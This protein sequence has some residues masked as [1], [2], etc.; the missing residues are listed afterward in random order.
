MLRTTAAVALGLLL[1]GQGYVAW[2]TER[3]LERFS[4][5]VTEVAAKTTKVMRWV[6]GGI[7][8]E[9]VVEKEVGESEEAFAAR[10]RAELDAQTA[11]G[12]FPPD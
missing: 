12:K 3:T 1:V 7:E 9:L 6:S 8:Q 10:C 4:R 11:P 5:E 2:R